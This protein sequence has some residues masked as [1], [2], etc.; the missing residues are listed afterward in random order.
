M[1]SYI[2][3]LRVSRTFPVLFRPQ[4]ETDFDSQIQVLLVAFTLALLRISSL[5]IKS[6][7]CVSKEFRIFSPYANG[8][9]E[10]YADALE[11]AQL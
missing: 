4:P 8:P 2:N 9:C 11:L 10:T 6:V 7:A 1:I 5:L 3:G